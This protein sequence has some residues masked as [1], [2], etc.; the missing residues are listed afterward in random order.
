MEESIN[1]CIFDERAMTWMYINE[2]DADGIIQIDRT[3]TLDDSIVVMN[4]DINKAIEALQDPEV[5][6]SIMNR[7]VDEKQ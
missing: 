2:V 4:M 1:V 5:F 7:N 3:D 6:T